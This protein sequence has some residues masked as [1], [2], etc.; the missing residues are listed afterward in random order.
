M[1]KNKNS[2][3]LKLLGSLS[4]EGIMGFMRKDVLH[5]FVSLGLIGHIIS[6]ELH[7]NG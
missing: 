7:I 6:Q 2:A 3:P 5:I 4:L 1:V